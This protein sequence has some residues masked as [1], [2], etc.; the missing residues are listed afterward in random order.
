M[1]KDEIGILHACLAQAFF[2]LLVLIALALSNKWRSCVASNVRLSASWIAIG[3][4]GL[5]Y[6]QLSLGATMRHQHRDLAIL[7]FPAAYGQVIP[8][9][10]PATLSAINKWREARAFSE[11]TAGQIWLQMAHRFV[12]LLIASAVIGYWWLMRRAAGAATAEMRTLST[13]WLLLLTAQ[14]ALGAWTIWSN[15]AADVATTHVAAGASMLAFGVV[16]SAMT[17]RCRS[18]RDVIR[19]REVVPVVEEVHA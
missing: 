1:R 18:A 10:A 2:G 7:D 3:A 19:A 12:A 4:T 9:V 14:I 16:I 17:L 6:L 8:D 11:V 5:I 15:K 13:W